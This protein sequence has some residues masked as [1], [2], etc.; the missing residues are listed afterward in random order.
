MKLIPEEEEEEEVKV[1]E[2]EIKHGTSLDFFIKF[3]KISVLT[4]KDGT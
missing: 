3:L 2:E 4:Q 1:N